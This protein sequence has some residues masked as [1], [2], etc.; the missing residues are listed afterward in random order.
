MPKMQSGIEG[1]FPAP[2]G[3]AGEAQSK[4]FSKRASGCNRHNGFTSQSEAANPLDLAVPALLKPPTY[5]KRSI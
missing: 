1:G 4:T 2:P 3:K 5:T